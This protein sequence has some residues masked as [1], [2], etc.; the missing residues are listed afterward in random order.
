MYQRMSF[1]A[2]IELAAPPTWSASIV[3]VFLGTALSFALYGVLDPLLF[4][5]TLAICITFQS[6]V[7]TLNDYTDFVK[8]ADTEDNTDDV[9]DASIVYNHIDPRSARNAGFAMIAIGFAIG[10]YVIART[11]FIALAFALVGVAVLLLYSVARVPLSDTPFGELT[12]GIVMGGVITMAVAYVQTCIVDWMMLVYAIPAITMIACIMLVNN[13]SDIEKD[14]Q[15][16]RNTLAVKLGRE[17]ATVLLFSAMTA[18]AVVAAVV[19]CM[20]F[21]RGWFFLPVM[22]VSAF[23][24]ARM[25]YHNGITPSV[26]RFNMQGVGTVNVRINFSYAACILLSCLV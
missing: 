24:P 16:G 18:A 22:A 12:S 14:A 26:R 25:M 9:N 1:K 20:L 17:K 4:L 8:G 2:L 21:P 10:A 7:N 13:T 23:I 15:A 6:A 3:P 5:S 19:V 11:S